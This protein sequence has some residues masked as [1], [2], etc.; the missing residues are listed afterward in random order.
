MSLPDTLHL[1]AVEDSELD[2]ELLVA[3]LGRDPSLAGV[4][5][6]AS[7]VED[8]AGMREAFARGRV[9]AVVTDHNMP[10]FDSFAALNVAKQIDP[11]LP[12]IVVSGEMSEELAVASLHAGADDFILKSRM[13][14]LAP[15]LKRSLQAAE[16]RRERAAQAQRLAVSEAQLR[17]LTQHLERLKEEE[18]RAIAREIH[19][20]IGTTLTA[21]KFELV[22]LARELGERP[23]SAPRIN[24]MQEL[25][26]HAVSASH[27]IQHNLRPPV[28]DAGLVAALEW[29]VK[30]FTERTAVAATFET[31][32][33]DVAM[34]PERAAALYRVA[35]ET[36]ANVAKHAQASR[37]SV[38]LFCAPDEVTL[39]VSDNGVGFDPQLLANTPGFGVRGLIERARGFSGW[40]EIN[41]AP[42]RGCTVMF[43]IPPGQAPAR[44]PARTPQW[45]DAG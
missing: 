16:T 15:A 34:A 32:R 7:R 1:L 45:A 28:L 33:D 25:L 5:V 17:E 36:L 31:N 41:A 14:R 38:H 21:L 12:V 26:T 27:R 35:Q 2:F 9:D 43:A 19:D 29:L 3:I 22:R 23:A 11:D 13:F 44:E 37:V 40:A 6:R 42:G 18:R 39:E 24:T 10:R 8:E 20:D 30:G 4:R